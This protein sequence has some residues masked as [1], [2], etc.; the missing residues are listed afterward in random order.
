MRL[1]LRHAKKL[2]VAIAGGFVV[3]VGVVAIPYPGPGWLIIFAGL[4]ILATEF[5][6]AQRLL[7]H[8]RAYYDSLQEQLKN[9]PPHM[10]IISLVATGVV[11]LTTVWLTNGLGLLN[12]WL[13]L[14]QDWLI[15]PFAR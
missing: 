5:T 11:I 7:D 6:W 4:A 8:L 15:S 9:Q 1:N 10:K 3:L 2:G 12:G 14:G 13:H